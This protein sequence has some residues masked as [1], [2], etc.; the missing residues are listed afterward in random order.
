MNFFRDLIFRAF[1]GKNKKKLRYSVG[2]PTPIPP[3]A[4]AP[5]H[6][7]VDVVCGRRKPWLILLRVTLTPSTTAETGALYATM[8]LVSI[9]K[10]L[11]RNNATLCIGTLCPHFFFFGNCYC[12]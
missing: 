9:T 7:P 12:C 10:D 4:N 5:Q 8:G 6:I 3:P 2:Q 1:S 11:K